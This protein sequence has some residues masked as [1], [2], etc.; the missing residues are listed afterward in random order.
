MKFTQIMIVREIR[1]RR[2]KGLAMRST[3]M[4]K[5]EAFAEF[6]PEKVASPRLSLLSKKCSKLFSWR[7]KKIYF[8]G[9]RIMSL[10]EAGNKLDFDETVQGGT[11]KGEEI[12]LI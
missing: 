7:C 3:N 6:R 4:E 11:H 5:G 10:D 2:K 1:K 12:A 8:S 9:N